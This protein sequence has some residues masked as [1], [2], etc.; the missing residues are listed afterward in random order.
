MKEE[1]C[2]ATVY[3]GT[4]SSNCPTIFITATLLLL[5]TSL[6]RNRDTNLF[7]SFFSKLKGRRLESRGNIYKLTTAKEEAKLLLV[8][9]GLMMR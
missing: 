1:S 7:S 8:C 3:P 6:K 5:Y 9:W 2:S 4:P